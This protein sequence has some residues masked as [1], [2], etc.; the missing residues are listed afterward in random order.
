M[1]FERDD[2]P[3][4]FFGD[5]QYLWD[6]ILASLQFRAPSEKYGRRAA[7]SVALG[8]TGR[9]D[10]TK[11][12]RRQQRFKVEPALMMQERLRKK[13]YAPAAL[14]RYHERMQD[15]AE[16]ERERER[17]RARNE[18]RRAAYRAKQGK[19]PRPEDM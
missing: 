11:A 8:T 10:G 13:K 16:R 9:L 18:A 6:R 15:P 1:T 4:G 3:Q 2:F 5:S 7:N 19:K 12:Q 14:K 17:H